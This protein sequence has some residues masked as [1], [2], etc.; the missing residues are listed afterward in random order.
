MNANNYFLSNRS[1]IE[2][3]KC[4]YLENST[5]RTDSNLIAVNG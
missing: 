2:L 4:K 5:N 1:K 3:K